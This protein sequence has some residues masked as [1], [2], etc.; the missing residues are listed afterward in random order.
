MLDVDVI[1]LLIVILQ[2][3][4]QDVTKK[5]KLEEVFWW[6]GSSFLSKEKRPRSELSSDCADALDLNQEMREVLIAP[7]NSSLSVEENICCVVGC[8]RYSIL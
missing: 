1:Y 3:L 5:L 8:E 7:A 4:L 2:L 6:K